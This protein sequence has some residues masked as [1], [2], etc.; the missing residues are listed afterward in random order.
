MMRITP[1]S[2]KK[3]VQNNQLEYYFGGTEA[4]VAISLA[5]LGNDTQHVTAVSD[6]F[7]GK[8]VVSYLKKH[9]VDTTAI[10]NSHHPLG[11]YF[12]EVGAVMRS[13]VI[14]YNRN[15][16]AFSNIDPEKIDWD[17]ILEGCDWIHWTGSSL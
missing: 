11:L 5:E 17:Q 12:L 7:I 2:N 13:S 9:N 4:N 1:M 15:N 6:D 14:S 8:A 3:L 16:T 10:L